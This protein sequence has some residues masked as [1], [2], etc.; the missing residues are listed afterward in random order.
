MDAELPEFAFYYPG[1]RWYDS[2]WVKNLLLFFDGIALLVPKHV[3]DRPFD[4]DPALATALRDHGLLKTIEPES[5]VDEADAKALED[6]MI[7]IISSGAFDTLAKS[8]AKAGF[9]EISLSRLGYFAAPRAASAIIN[10]LEKRKLARPSEDGVSVPMQP[11]VRSL[12]LNL[13]AQ[14]LRTKGTQIDLDLYPATDRPAIQRTLAG[15]LKDHSLPS[16]D[17]VVTLDL[18]TVGVD[19]GHTPIEQL[20]EFK[21]K[22]SKEYHRYARSLRDFVRDAALLPENDRDKKLRDRREEINDLAE[23][24]T[25]TSLHT[26][27]KRASFALSLLGAAWTMGTGDHI[28]ALFAVGSAVTGAN[29]SQPQQAGA[30]SYLF[31]ARST[32][33]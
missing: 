29:L 9:H 24:L 20:L 6:S 5:F 21:A 12:V 10:E 17:H 3:A 33:A 8:E 11:L 31:Q 4:F 2:D 26:W 15:L 16:A 1:P 13:L 32:L 25:K 14:I 23:S 18:Q 30:Y 22:H 7:K 19:L 28:G 27:G